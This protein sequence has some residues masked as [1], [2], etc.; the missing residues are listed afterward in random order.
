MEAVMRLRRRGGGA[1]SLHNSWGGSAAWLLLTADSNIIDDLIEKQGGGGWRKRREEEGQD[2]GGEKERKRERERRSLQWE[3]FTCSPCAQSHSWGHWC[4]RRGFQV[5]T[6]TSFPPISHPHTRS[7]LPLSSSSS[8]LVCSSSNTNNNQSFCLFV[9]FSSTLLLREWFSLAILRPPRLEYPRTP[10]GAH[11]LTSAHLLSSSSD[12][13]RTSTAASDAL[14]GNITRRGKTWFFAQR[15][16][17]Q[18]QTRPK[19]ATPWVWK[20]TQ[21]PTTTSPSRR[22]WAGQSFWCKC[23]VLIVQWLSGEVV[24]LRHVLFLWTSTCWVW[25]FLFSALRLFFNFLKGS[26]K[27]VVDIKK[28]KRGYSERKWSFTLG[29]W[30]WI[31]LFYF[32]SRVSMLGIDFPQVR[33]IG[34]IKHPQ[35]KSIK[36]STFSHFYFF[37]DSDVISRVFNLLLNC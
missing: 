4:E 32:S 24:S 19:R 21:S 33:M 3:K 17:Q 22:R 15:Q 14:W 29:K 2:E 16:R 13:T 10:P 12:A 26:N 18:R 5:F 30:I 25:L 11:D 37:V 36:I 28:W 20:P 27:E 31:L 1:G 6:R 23:L 7:T 34:S 8:P 35:Y 9:P